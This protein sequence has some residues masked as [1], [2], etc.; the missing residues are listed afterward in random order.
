[1]D[2]YNRIYVFKF[3]LGDY[4]SL[5]TGDII[6]VNTNKASKP[7]KDWLNFV[8]TSG[9][10]NK[11]KSYYSKLEKD[12]N[13]NYSAFESLDSSQLDE[14]LSTQPYCHIIQTDNPAEVVTALSAKGLRVSQYEDEFKSGSGFDGYNTGNYDW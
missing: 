1:M 11:I 5:K 3:S 13:G 10:K 14:L 9:A 7:S 8:V 6:K 12:E 2:I 4:A